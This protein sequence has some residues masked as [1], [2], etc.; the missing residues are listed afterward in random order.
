MALVSSYGID[1]KCSACGMTQQAGEPFKLTIHYR[2]VN[3]YGA[4]VRHSC[5][6]CGQ[7]ETIT[8]VY[9]RAIERRIETWKVSVR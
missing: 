3:K 6:N 5:S 7:V 4:E 2:W 1:H 9:G 8:N